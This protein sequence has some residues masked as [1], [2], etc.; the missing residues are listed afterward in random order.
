MAE[1]SRFRLWWL[2][3]FSRPAHYRALYRAIYD[4]PPQ[5]LLE[6][7]APD[8]RH[9]ERLIR[10]IRQAHPAQGLR[11]VAIHPF[12]AAGGVGV[13]E[14]YRTLRRLGADPVVLLPGALKD[15][16]P[17]WANRIGGLDLMILWSTAYL[18]PDDPLWFFVPRMLGERGWV[19]L[20]YRGQPSRWAVVSRAEALRRAE[21]AL[22]RRAA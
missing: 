16:L 11:Y 2:F 13:K 1:F 7:A 17:A 19:L 8:L 22:R 9:T 12:E 20:E 15:V 5:S 18:A 4:A 21:A 14:A 3:H 10:L 6:A